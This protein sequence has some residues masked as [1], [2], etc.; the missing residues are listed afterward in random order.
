MSC[1]ERV[2]CDWVCDEGVWC[3]VQYETDEEDSS[4]SYREPT[5]QEIEEGS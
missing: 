4:V 2:T 5:P 1:R 3:H